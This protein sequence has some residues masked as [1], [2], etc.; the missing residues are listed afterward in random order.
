MLSFFLLIQILLILTVLSIPLFSLLNSS[1]TFP[2]LNGCFNDCL[3]HSLAA[4]SIQLHESHSF[5]SYHPYPFHS[6]PAPH[7][8]EEGLS[9]AGAKDP[10]MSVAQHYKVL[11]FCS[12]LQAKQVSSIQQLYLGA[13]GLFGS[14]S[15]G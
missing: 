9:Y 4:C 12:R 5:S 2:P 10:Q 1:P 15:Q 8:N 13:Q 14:L 11:Y 6:P 3:Y 7:A